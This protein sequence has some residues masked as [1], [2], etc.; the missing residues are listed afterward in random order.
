MKKLLTLSWVE[1]CALSE[2]IHKARI[3]CQFNAFFFVPSRFSCF[4]ATLTLDF[5]H[6]QTIIADYLRYIKIIACVK[7]GT[8]NTW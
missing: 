6:I 4:R 5:L 8:V 7:T 2:K 3:S 1:F